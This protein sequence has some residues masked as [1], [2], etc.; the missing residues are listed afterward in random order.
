MRRLASGLGRLSKGESSIT[1]EVAR[2]RRVVTM[3]VFR[4]SL[5]FVEEETVNGDNLESNAGDCVVQVTSRKCSDEDA[6]LIGDWSK[7]NFMLRNNNGSMV[8][9]N[10]N[11]LFPFTTNFSVWRGRA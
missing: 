3:L 9:G 4:F 5:D 1:G 8:D 7:L 6:S 11:Y 10:G 2:A